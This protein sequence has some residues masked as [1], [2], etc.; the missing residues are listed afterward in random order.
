MNIGL[1]II[2]AEDW[3]NDFSEAMHRLVF[4]EIKPGDWDRID[5]SMLFIDR[6]QNTPIG[7]A[8]VY[9]LD[10]NNA[11][12]QFGGALEKYRGKMCVYRCYQL[13]IQYL[14]EKYKT[15]STRIENKN[16]AML[17]FAMREGFLI[18][19]IYHVNGFT[20]LEHVLGLSEG[21]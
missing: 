1:E 18:V 5:F 9:E 14:R 17:K 2:P 10:K 11:Y 3:K 20:M 13:G 8:T 6:E 15:V 21:V 4:N 12:M 16:K 19:G 7:Y